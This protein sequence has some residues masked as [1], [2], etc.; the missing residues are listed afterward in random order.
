VSPQSRPI[1]DLALLDREA[2]ELDARYAGRPVPR[3]PYWGGYRLEPDRF[4]F[5]TGR[6]FRLHERVLYLSTEDGWTRSLIGP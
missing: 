4:E 3:P 2:A 1:T 5:W 6:E